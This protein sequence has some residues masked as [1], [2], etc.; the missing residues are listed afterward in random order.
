MA[1]R[2]CDLTGGWTG[3]GS[4]RT[5][6][7]PR[8]CPGR[9][10]RDRRRCR[11][12]PLLALQAKADALDLRPGQPATADLVARRDRTPICVSSAATRSKSRSATNCRRQSPSTGT[13]STASAAA[14]PLLARP[15]LG[16]RRQGNLRD[17]V[18]PCRHLSVRPSAA[19]RWP[20]AAVRGA[21]ADRRGK[22]AVAV[23]RDE[24][25][26]IEDWRL[27]PDGTAIAPGTRPEGRD[28]GL[29]RQRANDSLEYHR[30]LP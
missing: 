9:C 5:D 3:A 2:I 18:A 28:A 8:S 24:V 21:G 20:G 6:G 1:K 7:R 22:R 4:P 19:R 14:E 12:P 13:A 10:P 11:G 15:P 26:L 30:P 17:S 25:L 23:D 27:R 16:A 29:H